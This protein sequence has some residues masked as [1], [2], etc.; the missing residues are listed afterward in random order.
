MTPDEYAVMTPE[1]RVAALTD[2]YVGE[3][4]PTTE[5]VF[6]L[7]EIRAFAAVTALYDKIGASDIAHVVAPRPVG[8]AYATLCAKLVEAITRIGEFD[9]TGDPSELEGLL[10]EAMGEV[11][12][13]IRD[14]RAG[15]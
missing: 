8:L 14:L 6:T 11:K 7:G 5:V 15:S 12:D 4:L 3:N 10:G 2:M 9:D 13:Q 1:E